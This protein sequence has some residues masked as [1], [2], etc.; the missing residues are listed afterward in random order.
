MK[1]KIS[2][3]VILAGLAILFIFQ[4]VTVVDIRFLFWTITVPR[5]ALVLSFLLT[6]L[7][8]GWFIHSYSIHG[9]KK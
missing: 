4:N 9:K 1:F 8:L 7:V 6:G 5:S 2:A 3:S